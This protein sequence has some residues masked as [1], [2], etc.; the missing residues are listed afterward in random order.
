MIR[1]GRF[2]EFVDEFISTHN[3][4]EDEQSIW[5]VYLHKIW[6]KSFAEFKEQIEIDREHQEMTESDIET[7]VQNS[8]KILGN[9]N[10]DIE[11]G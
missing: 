4:E 11:G 1:V 2:S 3:K 6:D 9:F 8:M 10:P 5:E 7:T